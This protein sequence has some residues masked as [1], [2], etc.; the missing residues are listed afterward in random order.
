MVCHTTL[1]KSVKIAK[2]VNARMGVSKT[3]DVEGIEEQKVKIILLVHNK[4]GIRCV[5]MFTWQD[6]QVVSHGGAF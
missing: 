3:T 4:R 5:W 6:G 1:L 2:T